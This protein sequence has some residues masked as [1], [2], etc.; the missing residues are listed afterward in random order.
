MAKKQP[1]PAN[2]IEIIAVKDLRLDALNP[3]LPT[4][5]AR[6]QEAMI[7]YLATTTSIEDLMS[8]IAENGY[9]P[10][11]P[12]IAVK[13]DN[14][15]LYDVVEGNRRLT[16]VILL[17]DPSRCSK[18]ST[19]MRE[20]SD[21]VGD[22]DELPVVVRATRQEVLPYLGFRHITGVKQWEPLAKARYLKQLF[23]MTNT[24]AVPGD[25]YAEVANAIGSRRD[26]VKRNLDA[27]AVY[28]VI[29]QQDFF[30][31]DELGEE[32]IKFSILSTALADE[33]IASFVGSAV[34]DAAEQEYLPT[35]PIVDADALDVHKVRK[36]A[37]WCFKKDEKGKT[38]L[39]ESRNLRQ[40]AAVVSTSKAL[41][42]L[43][44]GASLEYS[45][46]MTKGVDA[47]FLELLYEA[48]ATVRRAVSMIASV[49]YAPE[50]VDVARTIFKN[51][52]LIGTQLADKKPKDSED[53]F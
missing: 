37:E 20:L 50:A 33:N 42:A 8:A 41:E 29:E 26:H 19:R 22:F 28:E 52:R 17:N 38:V 48:E 24:T 14:E 23:D 32:S 5:V 13:R 4:T 11:E 12:L 1:Q 43:Q 46:R 25:R 39:G 9:F 53:E 30:E 51:V 18:P 21:S 7:D 31:I 36:L 49:D 40:L 3:R 35:N 6:T 27:L 34:W 15:D 44:N 16:A 45:Y 10:G 2:D 47:E